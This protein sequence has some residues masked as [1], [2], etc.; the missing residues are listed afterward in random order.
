METK[1][2]HDIMQTQ[3]TY[4]VQ[5]DGCTYSARILRN[6][7][8]EYVSYLAYNS[9]GEVMKLTHP[10]YDYIRNIDID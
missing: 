8:T 7:I 2:S 6:H 1:N 10:V 9:D 4:D 5:F 3:Y